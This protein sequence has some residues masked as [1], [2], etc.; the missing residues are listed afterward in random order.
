M[1]EGLPVI[2]IWSRSTRY[3]CPR[4]GNMA[5]ISGSLFLSGKTEKIDES[6]RSR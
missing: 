4:A 6:R 2:I 5:G 1:W 3:R